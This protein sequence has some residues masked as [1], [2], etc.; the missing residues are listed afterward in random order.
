MIVIPVIAFFVIEIML[1]YVL[2]ILFEGDLMEDRMG[3]FLSI[4]FIG[5]L[6]VLI[7]TNGLL[8][9]FVA[10]SIIQP[11][12]RLQQAAK[13]ISNGN[14]EFTIESSSRDELGQLSETFELMR[15]R[16]KESEE[17]QTRYAEN[18]K[19]LI[20]SIS[21]D[22][23]TPMTSIK[24][25]IEGIRDGIANTP[26]KMER[27]IETIYA[28][29]NDMDQLIDELFLYSKLDL[30]QVHY[31]FEHIDLWSY[32]SDFI[33]ELAFDLEEN[34]C[35]VSLFVNNQD[36]FI[37]QADREQLKRVLLNII[38]NSLKYMDKDEK[39]IRVILTANADQVTVTIKDNGIGISEEAIPFI[40]ER[41]Y[42]TDTSRNTATGGSGL[43]LAIVRRI[44][45]QHEGEIWAESK[46]GI[47]TSIS[48]TLPKV[49]DVNEKNPDYRR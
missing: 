17:L 32:L 30:N 33:E 40:F 3:L 1:G 10:K 25:Y 43:G 24:G 46:Q 19:E 14:L 35:N 41:F 11:V 44:I 45:E 8:T 37:V 39:E 21:H 38:Q 28:K 47:G 49:G 5:L 20:A 22:L 12:K 16:L 42:R 13:E 48:F 36:T 27:Y 9:Y 34:D 2:F 26:E 15:K 6:T 4:R 29:T 31:H 23:K 7:I 18:R